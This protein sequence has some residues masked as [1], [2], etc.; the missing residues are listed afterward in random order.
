MISGSEWLLEVSR[1]ILPDP[2]EAIGKTTASLTMQPIKAFTNGLRDCP[3]HGLAR[4]LRQFLHEPVGFVVFNIE[5]HVIIPFYHQYKVIYPLWQLVR[6]DPRRSIDRP[7][8][9]VW[10]R[11]DQP[12]VAG[13]QGAR[14]KDYA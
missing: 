3:G 11:A 1:T 6:L 9:R 7:Q 10:L 14:A 2:Q 8:I 13:A 5:S 4:E 12:D